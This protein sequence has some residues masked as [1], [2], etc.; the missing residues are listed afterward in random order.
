L[1]GILALCVVVS[2][3]V[4]LQ[5]WLVGMGAIAVIGPAFMLEAVSGVAI[6]VLLLAWR[7]WLPPLLAAGFALVTLGAFVVATG[8]AGLFSVHVMWRGTAEWTVAVAEVI[9]IVLGVITF[10]VERRPPR[11]DRRRRT[12]SEPES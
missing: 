11:R 9:A 7:H 2:G 6:G 3:L 5:L 12:P 8:P 1:R 10:V 4:H